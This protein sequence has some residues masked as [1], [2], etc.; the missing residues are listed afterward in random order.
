M[1]YYQFNIGDY[2]SHTSRLSLMED[3][4][5]RRLLDLY[6]L[7]E[8]PFNECLTSVA[9]EIGMPEHK[10]EIEYILNKFFSLGD[11]LWVQNRADKEIKVYQSKRKQQSKAGKASAEARKTK[12]SEQ[13]SNDRSTTVQPNIK[14]ETLN[15]KQETLKDNTS[16]VNDGFDHWWINYPKKA[17]KKK[18][19]A[20]FKVIT[21]GWGDERFT[22]FVNM[23]SKDC[24][25]RFANTEKSFIPNA[26][27][28]LNG[29]R[30]NDE[31]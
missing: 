9:R 8:Q 18:S 1:H 13:A 7:T 21:K 26:T 2:S 27:T 22:E 17:D 6:Y 5:Y 20:K 16:F 4:A 30:W 25:K 28:Y 12:A 29:E 24:K 15:T 3:L 31:Y 23:I 11:G 19:L 14:Q 10:E